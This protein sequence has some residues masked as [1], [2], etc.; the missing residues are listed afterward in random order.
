M[1]GTA[2]GI[3][4]LHVV[5]VAIGILVLGLTVAALC[6]G[7]GGS[8][9]AADPDGGPGSGPPLAPQ[10]ATPNPAKFGPVAGYLP[11]AGTT[12]NYAFSAFLYEDAAPR[13]SL[14]FVSYDNTQGS[15]TVETTVRKPGKPAHRKRYT[16]WFKVIG[17][18]SY[19]WKRKCTWLDAG[20]PFGPETT[21]FQP[22]ALV[23]LFSSS[24]KKLKSQWTSTQNGSPEPESPCIYQEY[25]GTRKVRTGGTTY[26][27]PVSRMTLDAGFVD[28]IAGFELYWAPG[29]GP[30]YG[31][32]NPAAKL[33]GTSSARLGRFPDWAKPLRVELTAVGFGPPS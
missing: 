6:T 21:V 25:A 20:A 31:E 3:R 14:K 4:A 5:S 32:L 23:G 15:V 30:V 13:T 26:T 24:P 11:P 29:V 7:C 8:E 22:G 12:L 27:A 16:L 18:Q 33:I 17:G 28:D 19:I 1:E 2:V 9:G 10:A